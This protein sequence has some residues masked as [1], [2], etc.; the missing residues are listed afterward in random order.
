MRS[1]TYD[2]TLEHRPLLFTGAG[3]GRELLSSWKLRF[4]SS[5]LSGPAQVLSPSPGWRRSWH[6]AGEGELGPLAEKQ[7][8]SH[9]RF[10][11]VRSPRAQGPPWATPHPPGSLWRPQAI[12]PPVRRRAVSPDFKSAQWSICPSSLSTVTKP[13]GLRH[14]PKHLPANPSEPPFVLCYQGEKTCI[15]T[16]PMETLNSTSGSKRGKMEKLKSCTM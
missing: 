12:T 14:V 9:S 15:P 13:G 7:E 4:P 5:H 11:P 10:T 16:I 2:P 1:L 6:L 3:W 8:T